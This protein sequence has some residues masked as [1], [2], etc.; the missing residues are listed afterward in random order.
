MTH[1]VG[2]IPGDG[3]FDMPVTDPVQG[4]VPQNAALDGCS[5][6]LHSHQ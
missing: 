6:A 2:L 3:I 4:G 5:A 1:A